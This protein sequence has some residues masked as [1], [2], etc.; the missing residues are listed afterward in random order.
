MCPSLDLG[1]PSL[2]SCEKW[3]TAHKPPCLCFFFI[4]S[5]TDQ[6]NG[7]VAYFGVVCSDCLHSSCYV[8]NISV[9]TEQSN[10]PKRKP[11]VIKEWCYLKGKKKRCVW[12]WGTVSKT[13][14]QKT[15]L[16]PALFSPWVKSLNNFSL[17]VSACTSEKWEFETKFSWVLSN[18]FCSI[19]LVQFRG[20]SSIK[21][22]L[23][24]VSLTMLAFVTHFWG[25]QCSRRDTR[26]LLRLDQKV[27]Q[28][29]C[30]SLSEPTGDQTGPA[31]T[32]LEIAQR[33]LKTARGSIPAV[34]SSSPS[35]REALP[36]LQIHAE[37]NAVVISVAILIS[38]YV[39]GW[40]AM[41][42]WVARTDGKA[43]SLWMSGVN[44]L[45]AEACGIWRGTKHISVW[46]TTI[47]KWFCR[48][49]HFNDWL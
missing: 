1:L 33:C 47:L 35:I 9:F 32:V 21:G 13:K 25:R 38:N 42:H 36:A 3:V 31:A 37:N 19:T 34:W 24:P 17:W 4:A 16:I 41:Q 15:V 28:H 22:N 39:W 8:N 26:R 20:H 46:W 43:R 44:I 14:N 2:W 18:W 27:T 11:V 40:A 49:H 7:K 23:I 30:L 12:F 48:L 29:L 6:D 5:Q 10:H 45:A